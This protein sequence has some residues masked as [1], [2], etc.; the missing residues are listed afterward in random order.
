MKQ[1]FLKLMKCPYCDSNLYSEK[2]YIENDEL[3]EGHIACECSK[4]PLLEGILILSASPLKDRLVQL[5]KK[6]RS[7]EAI[8]LA[9]T[10]FS[11]IADNLSK[12]AGFTGLGRRIFET[13]LWQFEKL[14]AKICYRKFSNG[15]SRPFCDFL[16]KGDFDNYLKDRFS[17]ESLWSLYPFIQVLNGHSGRLLDLSCGAGHSSFI[18]STNIKPEELFCADYSFRNLF[19]AKKYVVRDAAFLCIDANYPLPFL[20]GIFDCILMLDAFHSIQSRASLAREM[21]RVISPQGLLLLLH[22][23]SSLYRDFAYGHTLPP[24]GWSRLFKRLPVKVLPEKSVVEDFILKDKLDLGRNYSATNLNNSMALTILGSRDSSVF[25][26]YKNSW[27]SILTN[28]YNLTI[29]P[30]YSI[31]Y[32]SDYILLERNFPSDY[33]RREYPLTEKYLPEKCIIG[34][35]LARAIKGRRLEIDYSNASE[36]DLHDIERLMKNFVI[37]SVPSNYCG[38]TSSK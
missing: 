31:E 7:K 12:I 18:L 38:P 11:N 17:A 24:L 9:L 27:S 25:R 35:N 10:R 23:H 29:N 37:I 1:E 34:S 28:K 30:I 5:I 2:I 19:L 13:F 14:N 15:I 16:G 26:I 32:E 3:I 4:Y 21:E 20:D 22:E 6:R 36:K 33:F 8:G